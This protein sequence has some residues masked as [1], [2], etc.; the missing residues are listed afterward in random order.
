MG[1]GR[2]ACGP[3]L[4]M[5]SVMG[6]AACF[7][8][9]I[10]ALGGV[11]GLRD[12]LNAI[13]TEAASTQVAEV[14]TQY[15]LGE[16]DLAAQRY[17]MA[18]IRFGFVMTEMPEYADAGQQLQNVE[19][20]L[21]VSPTPMATPTVAISP[22]AA[23]SSN[24]D[25]SADTINADSPTPTTDAF[26]AA[27]LY[28]LAETAMN[29]GD[30]EDAIEWLEA[31]VVVDPTYRRAEV[32]Q[33]RLDAYIAQGRL[34][35]RSQNDDG[36]ERLAQGVQLINRASELGEVPGEVLYEADF[37][38]RYL[39]ARAYVEGGA[40]AQAIEVLT[41][42]CQEDCNWTYNGQ[43]VQQLLWQAGG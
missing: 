22:T 40:Y 24:S 11:A 14:A 25:D 37:V 33:M 34:Y 8:V 23:A 15:A 5:L 35:L 6:L 36:E 28:G 30:Y 9:S 29:F 27:N 10:I 17:E 42:L 20:L 26:S 31:L 1:S 7:C 41:V 12:E 43:S 19:Q 4:M 38:A 13:S 16:Q 32:Q 2:L 21:A 39:A 18:A 3:V